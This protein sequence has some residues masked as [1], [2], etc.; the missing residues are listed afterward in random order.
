MCCHPKTEE[1]LCAS[2][3]GTERPASRDSETD[4]CVCIAGNA[5]GRQP[6][7]GGNGTGVQRDT[8]Y[9]LTATDRHAVFG[10]KGFGDYRET[11]TAKSIMAQDDITTGDLIA[12]ID[13]RNGRETGSVCGTLQAKEN[14]GYSLH[15]THPVRIGGEVRRLMPLECCRLQG[16]P[17]GWCEGVAGSDS[18]QYRMWGNGVALPCVL[19][20]MEG[21]SLCNSLP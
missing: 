10:F 17:D 12:G 14:G 19:Y 11:K 2:G 9:T 1:T 13:C 20:V 8:A 21:I 16:F 4:F 5:I 15:T 6:Q 7:N 18:A 3:A